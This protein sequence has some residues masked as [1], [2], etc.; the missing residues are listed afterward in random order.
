MKSKILLLAMTILS[1]ASCK[2]ELIDTPTPGPGHG[3]EE[4][5]LEVYEEGG[6]STKSSP[7]T[8]QLNLAN[9]VSASSKS[10]TA[11]LKKRSGSNWINVDSG[12]SYSWSAS[13]SDNQIFSGSG[14]TGQTC[15]VSAKA[16]GSGKINVSASISGSAVANQD[17]PVT[18]SDSRALSWSDATT[19]LTSGETKT[20]VLNSNFSCTAT[21]TS[22]NSNF[23][24]GTAQNNLSSSATV[25]F[26]DSKTKT[27]YYKYTGSEETTVTI[28]ANVSSSIESTLKIQIKDKDDRAIDIC[29]WDDDGIFEFCCYDKEITQ[30]SANQTSPDALFGNF[31]GCGELEEMILWGYYLY[32]FNNSTIY[33]KYKNDNGIKVTLYTCTDDAVFNGG[34]VLSE[35]KSSSCTGQHMGYQEDCDAIRLSNLEYSLGQLYVGI[36]VTFSDGEEYWVKLD[37]T[38]DGGKHLMKTDCYMMGLYN[39]SKIYTTITT[40]SGSGQK[41]KIYIDD[42]YDI[43]LILQEYDGKVMLYGPELPLLDETITFTDNF[44]NKYNIPSDVTLSYV[45][46]YQVGWVSQGDRLW[47][48]A[49]NYPNTNGEWQCSPNNTY[50]WYC[51]PYSFVSKYYVR[52]ESDVSITYVRYVLDIDL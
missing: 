47:D 35:C 10:I 17:V 28:K 18:V 32:D 9:L 7:S 22:N 25:T 14:T 21:I 4:Y 26:T 34:I 44:G 27:I 39:S 33:Q 5:M 19:S 29:L 52:E 37:D 11:Q 48:M 31:H 16:E 40:R 23:L 2:K 13:A 38:E 36:K 30:L 20:A 51:S 46:P 45:Q 1:L 24:I 3:D 12:V 6:T 41:E 50:W 43:Y 15:T 42:R 8:V 49:H